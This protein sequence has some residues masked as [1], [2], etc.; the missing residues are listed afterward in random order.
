MASWFETALT[1]LLTM[2]VGDLSS[3]RE[4]PVFLLPRRC[5]ADAVG[6]GGVEVEIREGNGAGELLALQRHVGRSHRKAGA[7][8]NGRPYRDHSIPMLACVFVI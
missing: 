4:N 2:R 3:P 7:A 8:G 1:R 6:G 5:D